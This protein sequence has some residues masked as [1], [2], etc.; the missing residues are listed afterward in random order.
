M[1]RSQPIPLHQLAQKL[2]NVPLLVTP[3]VA[4]IVSDV[5]AREIGS[6]AGWAP[7]RD[8]D[9]Q[10]F[11][12]TEAQ[13]GSATVYA[14]RASGFVGTTPRDPMTGKPAPY[15]V[16][17]DGTAI[18]RIVGEL[19]NRGEW[20]D[21]ESG[22]ISY[23]GL[24]HQAA[25]AEADPLVKNVVVDMS[26]PGGEAVGCFDCAAAFRR[27]SAV[28]PVIGF[29][30]GWAC[31]AGYALLSQCSRI[32]SI[33]EGRV[34]SIGVLMMHVDYSVALQLEGVKPTFLFAGSHKVD[35]NPF[36]PLPADVQARFQS[37]IDETYAMFV[38]TVAAGR[39]SLTEDAIRATQASIYSGA[40]A[41]AL[42]LIDSV[43]TFEDLL[44]ELSEPD[45]ITIDITDDGGGE[46]P[47]AEEGKKQ[48]AAS[49]ATKGAHA[50]AAKEP[51]MDIKKIMIAAGVALKLID[52]AEAAKKK[53]PATNTKVAASSDGGDCPEC[54]SP[55]CSCS[56][57][58]GPD[59]GCCDACAEMGDEKAKGRSTEA[60]LAVGHLART[61]YSEA[62]TT[63]APLGGCAMMA[64]DRTTTDLAVVD[65]AACLKAKIAAAGMSA[66]GAAEIIKTAADSFVTAH[67]A[68]IGKEG[69][70]AFRARFIAAKTANDAAALADLETM[71]ASY[72]Q[73][74]T[75]RLDTSKAPDAAQVAGVAATK[76]D[77]HVDALSRVA[78]LGI[79]ASDPRF[80]DEYGKARA[81]I[82]KESG[83]AN[84]AA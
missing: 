17:S 53:A 47:P 65:C 25:T 12:A 52:E 84:A 22:L 70:A 29:V 73:R 54:G 4:R 36:A 61:H 51:E 42:G 40:D 59:C 58:T 79:T 68:N 67:C 18:I 63:R 5:L 9:L 64:N 43:G 60:R 8:A 83:V 24:K 80:G 45:V 21:A 69:T 13:D 71:A 30:N 26:T 46:A 44:V 41:L 49:P 55:D 32:V 66:D 48:G 33:P 19:V 11:P 39:A 75:G 16:T 3:A 27:L 78:A 14:T 62:S 35:G 56:D 38:S 72:P 28:K 10:V 15:K 34:G 31:S 57:C 77:V 74:T 20:L 82:L 7:Q 37:Q 23:E 2:Y 81:A 6:R 1:P 50:D 76:L